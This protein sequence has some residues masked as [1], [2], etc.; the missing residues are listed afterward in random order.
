V[1]C[2]NVP[3]V[4]N[5]IHVPARAFRRFRVCTASRLVRHRHWTVAGVTLKRAAIVATVGEPVRTENLMQ[6]RPVRRPA[7]ER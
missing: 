7:R 5:N 6:Q 4:F 3:D 1:G 2:V